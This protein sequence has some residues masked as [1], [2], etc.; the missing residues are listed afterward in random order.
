MWYLVKGFLKVQID[1]IYHFIVVCVICVYDFSKDIQQVCQ[2]AMLVSESLL[3][4]AYEVV[5]LQVR[6]YSLPLANHSIV[7]QIQK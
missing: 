2:A 5:N 6:D 4:V 1:K 3:R 7:L